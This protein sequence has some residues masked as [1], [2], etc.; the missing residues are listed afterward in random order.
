MET[1]NNISTSEIDKELLDKVKLAVRYGYSY[2]KVAQA[3]F[4]KTSKINYCIP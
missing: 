1:K 2:R 3:Q 4:N